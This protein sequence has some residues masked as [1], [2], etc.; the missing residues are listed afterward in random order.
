LVASWRRA[1]RGYPAALRC[2]NGP[3]LAGDAALDRMK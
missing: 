1:A 3:E 2:D